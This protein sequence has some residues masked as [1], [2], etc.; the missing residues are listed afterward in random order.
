MNE[1]KKTNYEH[2]LEEYIRARKDLAHLQAEYDKNRHG[3]RVQ[4]YA[5]KAAGA[6]YTEEQIRSTTITK[7]AD[8][9]TNVILAQA[10]LD[11][12]TAILNFYRDLYNKENN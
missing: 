7:F 5:E 12:A 11:N 8:L 9:G 3:M 2:A 1:E 4:L 10:D 6:K